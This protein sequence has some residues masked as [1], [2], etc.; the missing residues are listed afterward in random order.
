MNQKT[1][2]MYIVIHEAHNL[3]L[4]D[5]RSS[6]LSQ[7]RLPGAAGPDDQQTFETFLGYRTP[8]LIVEPHQDSHTAN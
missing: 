5:R 2:F 3:V 6:D 4:F 1:V 8:G 7:Y